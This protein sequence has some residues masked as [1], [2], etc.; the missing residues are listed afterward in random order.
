[1]HYFGAP[2]PTLFALLV[3]ALAVAYAAWY[4]SDFVV[5]VRNGQCRCTGKLALV[6]QRALADF[7]LDDLR[8]PGPVT[9]RGKRRDGRLL[10]RF[11]GKL[12]PGEKQRIRNFLLT[13][14]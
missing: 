12:T 2:W 1:M 9:I 7:I 14:R 3:V 4:H 5:R 6:A 10:L 8:P 11:W 13:H